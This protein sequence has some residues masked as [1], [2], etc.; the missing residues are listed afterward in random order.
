MNKTEKIAE[1]PDGESE[2]AKAVKS[3]EDNGFYVV[4]ADAGWNRRR[5]ELPP[6]YPSALLIQA[7]PRNLMTVRYRNN[8]IVDGVEAGTK[9]Y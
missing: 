1:Q 9:N 2:L 6:F 3:L 5:D 8:I 4:H 7:I